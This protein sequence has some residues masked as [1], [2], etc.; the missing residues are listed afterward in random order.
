MRYLEQNLSSENSDLTDQPVVVG[1]EGGVQQLPDGLE[2][3]V[4]RRS[5]ANTQT[6]ES[7]F[8]LKINKQTR[9]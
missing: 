4:G 3:A 1:K 5:R 7:T 2:L 9:R 8:F 6:L